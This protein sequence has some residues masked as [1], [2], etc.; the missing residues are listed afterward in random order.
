MPI[1]LAAANDGS[2]SAPVAGN[3]QKANFF[4]GYARQS[5]QGPYVKRPPWKVAGVDYAIGYPS[6]TVFKVPGVDSLPT[7]CSLLNGLITC[8][9]TGRDITFDG[10]NFSGNLTDIVGVG[11]NHTFTVKN[12]YHQIQSN[13]GTNAGVFNFQIDNSPINVVFD[14]CYF[15]GNARTFTASHSGACINLDDTLG[16]S[17]TVSY[18][19]F[20][21]LPVGAIRSSSFGDVV[22]KYNFS[23][24][25]LLKAEANHGEF[26]AFQFNSSV[27]LFQ[28]S[29]NTILADSTSG[30]VSLN[31]ELTGGLVIFSGVVGQTVGTVLVNNN[32]VVANL[33]NG[34]NTAAW[35][36]VVSV[37]PTTAIFGKMYW[38]Y[39]Y[40]DPTGALGCISTDS[41]ATGGADIFVGNYNMLT[42]L[43][44]TG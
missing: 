26:C 11:G 2:S 5:G 1:L 44:V 13:A 34:D 22:L 10:W 33:N 23:E 43:L 32:V 7:G 41:R 24:F 35:C 9:I 3:F 28:Q 12:S 25:N 21:D 14:K 15:D 30:D 19:A 29:F 37:G 20:Y 4:T 6:A 17:I 39:N 31:A 18:C 36:A 8:D 38:G 42:G 16:N 40:F 27:N